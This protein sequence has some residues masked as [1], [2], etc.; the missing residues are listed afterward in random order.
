MD[1]EEILAKMNETSR[2]VKKVVSDHDARLRH[3]E[4]NFPRSS[5]VISIPGLAEEKEKF[6][7]LRTIRALRTGNWNDAPFEK[8]IMDT[9]QRTMGTTTG[10]AGGFL[11]PT[12][13]FPELIELLAA[14]AVCFQMGATFLP[15]LEGGEVTF[16]KQT[17]GATCYWVTEGLDI[18]ASDLA[19]GQLILRPKAVAALLKVNNQLIK[20]SN[21][22]AEALVRNDI[23]KALAREV[24]RVALRGE[25]T[26][27]RP[28]GIANTPN[29]GTYPLGTDGGYL[30]FEH[31]TD[32]EGVLEDANALDGRL[33]V[34]WHGKVKRR[35]KKMRIPQW[36]GDTA[37]QYVMLPMTDQMLRDLL[38]Y[39]FRVSSQIP[40]DLVKGTSEDC[41]EVY[42][43]NWEELLIGQW[44]GIE[45]LASQETSDAFQKN[46]TWI[47]VIQEV[48]CGLRHEESFCLCS[49]AKT[50]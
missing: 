49:D 35:L 24:D 16:V 17:G 25:G 8:E 31:I 6:S 37:G 13:L 28:L 43:G 11:V 41:S 33:G 7:I 46:Q 14:K 20:R 29:I 4:V 26:E 2:L 42:F 3:I 23:T 22:A 34:V 21:P 45:I 18:T 5:R 36:N 12:Q 39:D 27:T 19:F 40:T 47:R 32:M 30:L 1:Y 15:N 10:P 50:T 44:G 9:V 48:D 38:G